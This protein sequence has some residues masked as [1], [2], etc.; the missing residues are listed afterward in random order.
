ME[1]KTMDLTELT[2]MYDFTGQTIV[3]TGG[4]GILGG[5]IACA[6]A[7]NNNA[8]SAT[9]SF[10]PR[11][12]ARVGT[13]ISDPPSPAE[14][15]SMKDKTTAIMVTTTHGSTVKSHRSRQRPGSGAQR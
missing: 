13:R 15:D 4:T 10:V 12:R 3:V 9:P 14:A 8:A 7:A 6:A 5:E 1:Y 2:R 11:T